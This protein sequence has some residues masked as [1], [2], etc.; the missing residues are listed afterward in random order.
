M[1]LVTFA[2]KRK[3]QQVLAG[4]M[5][6][7]NTK[8]MQLRKYNEESIATDHSF[9]LKEQKRKIEAPFRL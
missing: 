7:K 9:A 6:F 8:I 5:C 2:T 4:F 3:Q 1:L